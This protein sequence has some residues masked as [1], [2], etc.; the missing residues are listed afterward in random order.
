MIA[1]TRWLAA[2]PLSCLMLMAALSSSSG[3]DALELCKNSNHYPLG[4]RAVAIVTAT[5][6]AVRC[7][8]GGKKEKEKE[9]VI[10][11]GGTNV[12]SSRLYQPHYRKYMQPVMRHPP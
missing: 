4:N 6:S 9:G 11:G 2:L 12:C 3:N 8:A 5:A 7:G 10:G 1:S